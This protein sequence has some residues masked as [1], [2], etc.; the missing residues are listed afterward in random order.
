[1]QS[2]VLWGKE[3]MLK[4]G[5]IFQIFLYVTTIAFCCFFYL[6]KQNSLT[7][8]RMYAPKLVK[9]LRKIE[10]ENVRLRCSIQEFERPE[11]LMAILSLSQYQHLKFPVEQE[12]L[13][14]AGQPPLQLN[15]DVHGST[16]FIKIPQTLA[17][18]VK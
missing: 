12:V 15:K 17:F 8:L 3:V 14:V 1:M 16:R 13:V 6:E 18:G 10:E 5:F 4:K 2:C 9:E 11:N 7:E